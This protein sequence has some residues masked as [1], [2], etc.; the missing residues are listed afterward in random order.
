[1]EVECKCVD[2]FGRNVSR[3]EVDFYIDDEYVDYG[4][5]E[6]GTLYKELHYPKI[7]QGQHTLKIT[8]KGY[9]S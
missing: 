5:V 3:Q 1:M 7:K 8:T 4:M 6:D 9:E 2:P